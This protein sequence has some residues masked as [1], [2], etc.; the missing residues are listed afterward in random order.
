MSQRAD[1]EPGV[2]CWVDTLQPDPDAAI[3]FYAGLFGWEFAGPGSM[4]GN[5]PGRYFVA[6]LRGRDVAGVGSQPAGDP[7]APAWTTYVYVASADDAALAAVDAGGAILVEPFG[8]LPAGRMAVL[9]DPA[10]AP[11]CVWEAGERRGAQLVNEPGA[12]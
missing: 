12:W 1:Y 6:R 3:A 4:P 2:P 7:P 8:V 11:F 10:G 9:A 5:P